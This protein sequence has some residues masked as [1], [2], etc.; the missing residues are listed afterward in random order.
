MRHSSAAS[1]SSIPACVG[2]SPNLFRSG[3]YL[4]SFHIKLQP[5]VGGAA[6][7]RKRGF[8]FNFCLGALASG[9]RQGLSE[10][11]PSCMRRHNTNAAQGTDAPEMVTA[12]AGKVT[13]VFITVGPSALPEVCRR[14]FLFSMM[15]LMVLQSSSVRSV[16]LSFTSFGWF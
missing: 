3:R 4:F 10:N 5:A 9:P 2:R 13:W 12:A 14:V 7:E 6:K 1:Q 11:F 16:G 8:I 15:G